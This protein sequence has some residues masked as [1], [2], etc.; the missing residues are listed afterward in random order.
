MQWGCM[1]FRLL[2]F[3]DLRLVDG[4]GSIVP[5]PEKGLLSICFLLTSSSTQKARAELAEFLW[6]DIPLDKALANLRQTL[7]R[8]KNRQD[9]LGIELL[10]IDQATVSVNVRAFTN[11]LALLTAVSQT[12]P[13]TALEELEQQHLK[14]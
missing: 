13:H 10:L 14:H 5:F 6:G 11:D 9:E 2:T 4:K 1:D 3:G 7:S 8:V 12:N